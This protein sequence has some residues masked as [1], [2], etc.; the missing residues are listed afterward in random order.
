[1]VCLSV[2]FFLPAVYQLMISKVAP[3]GTLQ[4]ISHSD[5]CVV[6]SDVSC[7]KQRERVFV[8]K[9]GPARAAGSEIHPPCCDYNCRGGC[10]LSLL[11]LC[12]SHPCTQIGKH[13]DHGH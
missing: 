13:T 8:F 9:G 6:S 3:I 5:V 12:L 7:N 4:A 1:M 10:D 2:I 11:C